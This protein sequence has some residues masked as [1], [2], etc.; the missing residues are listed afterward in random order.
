[1]PEDSVSVALPSD[2][3]VETSTLLR[4]TAPSQGPSVQVF[5][6]LSGGQS[7][8]PGPEVGSMLGGPVFGFQP[9]EEV[10]SAP[11]QGQDTSVRDHG[12][13]S[14]GSGVGAWRQHVGVVDSLYGTP[15]S[16]FSGA[17]AFMNSGI[18][19][20]QAAPHMLV[21][22]NPFA[23]LNQFGQLG[24]MSPTYLPSGKQ[25]DWKHTP[26][27]SSNTGVVGMSSEV[28][29]LVSQH[30]SGVCSCLEQVTP[31]SVW[32]VS[33]TRVLFAVRCF[34]YYTSVIRCDL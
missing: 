17:G 1:M 28:G 13:G 18:P 31:S 22:T 23:P 21:Y 9:G 33:H 15:P 14:M 27:L 3:S 8:F 34:A 7:P 26:V 20:I 19:N 12:V 24:F 6:G 5:P 2:L 4:G 10:V 30:N 16:S 11:R 32:P 25:P 29:G